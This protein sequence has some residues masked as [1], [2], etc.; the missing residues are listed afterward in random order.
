MDVLKGPATDST[1]DCTSQASGYFVRLMRRV[2]SACHSKISKENIGTYTLNPNEINRQ[3]KRAKETSCRTSPTIAT[4]CYWGFKQ[5]T[6]DEI[7]ISLLSF[8]PRTDSQMSTFLH[9]RPG[10]KR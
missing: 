8:R 3:V 2:E 6:D 7:E 4:Y 10:P 5:S 1:E 9:R